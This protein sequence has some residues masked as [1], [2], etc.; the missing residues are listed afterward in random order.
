MSTPTAKPQID[1]DGPTVARTLGLEVD[2]FREL[3]NN[4]KIS[5][6]CE[7]GT[8]EDE[9]RYRAS[10]YYQHKRARF[11]LDETGKILGQ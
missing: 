7:R 3:M 9:G 2:E 5:V 4:G 8:G 11:I 6:L 10:F 1:I